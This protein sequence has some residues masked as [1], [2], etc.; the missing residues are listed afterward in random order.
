M[1]KFKI[2]AKFKINKFLTIKNKMPTSVAFW[3]TGNEFG[4][5]IKNIKFYI[6]LNNSRLTFD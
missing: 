5:K 6:R 3:S 1:N 2:K 4:T